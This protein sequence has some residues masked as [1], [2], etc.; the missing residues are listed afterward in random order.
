VYNKGSVIFK[1][2]NTIQNKFY[3]IAL[4]NTK[5]M[6]RTYYKLRYNEDLE[7]YQVYD[8]HSNQAIAQAEEIGYLKVRNNDLWEFHPLNEDDIIELIDKSIIVYA[9]Y[10][11]DTEKH[12]RLSNK[13]VLG[14]TG[15]EYLKSVIASRN[16]L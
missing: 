5:N 1:N 6:I 12:E 16:K 4:N 14:W 9:E 15:E 2:S 8:P 7:V 3:N 11:K 13:I 10:D